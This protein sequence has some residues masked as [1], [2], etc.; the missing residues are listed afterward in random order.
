M[1][2]QHGR[3]KSVSEDRSRSRRRPEGRGGSAPGA[4]GTDVRAALARLEQAVERLAATAG[5]AVASRAASYVN[6]LAER[7]ERGFDGRRPKRRRRRQRRQERHWPLER[8]PSQ[9]LFRDSQRR[10]IAGV[11][12]GI[13]NY[14]G[15]QP[16]VV[17]CI[18]LTGLIFLPSIVFP[19]YWI[20]FF[21]MS[22]PRQGG[23]KPERAAQANAGEG[24][25]A[26]AAPE[27]GARVS[28]RR[29]L[30]NV[31][32]DLMQAELRLRRMEFHVTSGQYDLHKE[33]NELDAGERCG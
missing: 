14:Y 10:K 16:W 33:F 29:S 4:G 15:A 24:A 30:R 22:R 31:Q 19:A 17:R 23:A 3:G 5:D 25:H 1:A 32:A 8:P 13:A 26:A 28:P 9:R 11:C 6:D 2:A 20:L 27:L 21:V 18:A 12:A 7:F